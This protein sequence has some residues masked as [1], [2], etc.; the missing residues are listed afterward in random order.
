M[1]PTYKPGLN[2]SLGSK[3]KIN[4]AS[5][6]DRLKKYITGE[7]FTRR[8]GYDYGPGYGEPMETFLLPF[9]VY[10]KQGTAGWPDVGKPDVERN[11]ANQSK[12]IN[13]I[14]EVRSHL[15]SFMNPGKTDITVYLNGLDESY[16]PEAWSRMVYYGNM[17]QENLS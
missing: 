14:K 2:V 12:Y 8:Y 5:F 16:F 17:F 10:G 15:K 13:T 6:D 7:A 11:P 3:I 1:D 4:W 9:D